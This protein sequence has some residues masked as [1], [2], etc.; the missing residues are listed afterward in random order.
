MRGLNIAPG[1]H[2]QFASS[3][4]PQI[5][6]A[7]WQE[8]R[9]T[10]QSQIR[11]DV[12]LQISGTDVDPEAL[13][14]ARYHAREAGVDS[15]IHFQQKPFA[16]FRSKRRYGVIVT[17]PPYG[18]R[19][20]EQRQ[21]RSLYE[22]FPAVLQRVPTW[23]FFVLT[24]MP[25]FEQILQKQATRRRKLFNGRIECTYYQYPGPRPPRGSLTPLP[26]DENE[27]QS[28]TVDQPASDEAD[29]GPSD[30]VAEIE[31]VFGGLRDR[32]H[33]QAE[34]FRSRL[35]KRARHLRRWPTRRGITCFR[36]YERDIPEIPLV[37]DRYEDHL[38]ITEYER[39]HDRDLARH[40]QWLE[41]MKKTAATALDIPIQ[42]TVLKSR[43][44]N[45]QQYE[46]VDERQKRTEVREGGLRFLVNL[47]DYVDTGLFLD[48]RQ[49]RQMVRQA[50]AGKRFLNLFAYTGSFTVYAADGGATATTT[51]DLS[52]NYLAWAEA[53]LDAN[54]LN[55]PRHQFVAADSLGFLHEA[56]TTDQRF[57][58]C[59]VD[60]PTWSNSK[61][62]DDDWEVQA[63]HVE[64]LNRIAKIMSPGGL[65]FF[66][67]NF[68][69][70]KFE[71]SQLH[72][73]ESI[74]EITRQTIPE[75]FR[76]QRIHRCWRLVVC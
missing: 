35:M 10:A 4:W 69:R 56:I 14:M 48:H 58:L 75:D 24:S 23:S 67:T 39:P 29:S 26:R 47:T 51:V 52:K 36:V 65:V 40:A 50:A 11:K 28:G 13:S 66:S 27:S 18:Q 63:G 9:E 12:E 59:V 33:T 1:L 46:K 32:D 7:C 74:R 19:L 42:R 73:F 6:T 20:E 55:G 61:R 16:E 54:N 22:E 15:R 72:G 76:N 8:S 3:D 31:P 62:T 71:E 5:T 41:L 70:F 45:R 68:R 53:N 21:L 57:D 43:V 25:Q 64:L 44:K 30:A 60:P 37:V 2:R 38:H 49:T 17:N 34:L